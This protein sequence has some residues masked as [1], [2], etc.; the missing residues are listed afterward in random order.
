MIS[1]APYDPQNSR[2][3][4]VS[5]F[6]FVALW[7]VLVMALWRELVMALW[8]ELVMAPEELAKE[9]VKEL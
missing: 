5:S 6:H 9:L 1:S 8:R 3:F 2:H 7:I 4:V